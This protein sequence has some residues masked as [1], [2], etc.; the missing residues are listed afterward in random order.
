MS[1]E[2]T[3]K[4][5]AERARQ[6]AI[7]CRLLEDFPHELISAEVSDIANLLCS[8]TGNVAAWLEEE[9]AQRGSKS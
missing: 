6:A 9:S 3:L 2:I 7:I 4:Q 8:L 5:A 1:H